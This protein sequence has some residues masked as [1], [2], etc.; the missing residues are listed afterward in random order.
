MSAPRDRGPAPPEPRPDFEALV[1]GRST[2][3]CVTAVTYIG[4]MGSKS[5]PTAESKKPGRSIKEKR[6]AKHQKQA[7]QKEVRKGW[8]AK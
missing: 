2:T 8:D 4:P 7:E 5:K 1:P 6:A 3:R